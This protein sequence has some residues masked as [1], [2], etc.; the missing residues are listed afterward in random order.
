LVNGRLFQ[1]LAECKT[2]LDQTLLPIA[3]RMDDRPEI[4]PFARPVAMI[5]HLNMALSAFPIDG[6]IPTLVDATDPNKIAGILAE[7]LPAAL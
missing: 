7:T 4:K 3:A 5:E 1:D 2:Y 6:L